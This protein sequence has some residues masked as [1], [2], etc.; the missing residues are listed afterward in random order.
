MKQCSV[1]DAAGLLLMTPD[2][3]GRQPDQ[4][5]LLRH[6]D[7]WDLPKGHCEPGE[8]LL[9]TALRETEEETGIKRSQIQVVDGFRFSLEYPVSYGAPQHTQFIKRVCYFLGWLQAPC[10]VQC[11]EHED[12][13]WFAWA[14]PHKIQAQTIDPLLDAADKYFSGRRDTASER[15]PSD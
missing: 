14:P 3:G 7:R 15:L 1:V 11:T 8:T 10:E 4:F 9:E 13:A 12:F 5:L 6:R 2:K